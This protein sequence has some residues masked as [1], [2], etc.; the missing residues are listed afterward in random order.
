MTFSV[1]KFQ[2]NKLDSNIIYNSKKYIENSLF[3]SRLHFSEFEISS[4]PLRY[5]SECPI[6]EDFLSNRSY[7]LFQSISEQNKKEIDILND[8]SNVKSEPFNDNEIISELYTDLNSTGIFNL[9]CI[10]SEKINNDIK[11]N[12][13][14][15]NIKDIAENYAQTYERHN[16]FEDIMKSPLFELEKYN[17]AKYLSDC[18]FDYAKDQGIYLDDLSE[19]M[20][21]ALNKL[22][23]EDIIY[24]LSKIDIRIKYVNDKDDAPNGKIDKDYIQGV[25]GD[26]WLIA[27]INSIANTENGLKILNDSLEVL[28]DGSVKVTLKGVNKQYVVSKEQLYGSDEYSIGDTD[29]RAI[30]IAVERYFNEQG[31]SFNF[32]NKY[33]TIEKGGLDNAAYRILTGRDNTSEFKG[34]LFEYLLDSLGMVT[35]DKF[36][37]KIKDPNIA[38]TVSKYSFFDKNECIV[39]NTDG[40]DVELMGYHSYSA[41]NA[42]DENVYIKNPWDTSKTIVIPIDEFNSYFTSV[43]YVDLN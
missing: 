28:D 35:N 26:C 15:D 30:E 13:N 5:S 43:C 39:K 24:V 34:T 8:S 21:I 11:N 10:D 37:Q 4:I 20:D 22:N 3:K 2:Y 9:P 18:Y 25:I 16:L 23:T 31:Y 12:I 33:E 27:A 17:L 32:I 1:S 38:C 42:D 36:I 19:E 29:V 6:Q 7:S 41:V 14:V 40:E